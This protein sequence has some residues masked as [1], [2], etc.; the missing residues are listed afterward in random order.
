[1]RVNN[2]S[3]AL[4]SLVLEETYVLQISISPG[5]ATIILDALEVQPSADASSSPTASR[6]ISIEFTGVTSVAGR[7][8]GLQPATDA[9]GELD[10]GELEKLE[11][12]G[13]KYHILGEF[14]AIDIEAVEVSV[15]SLPDHHAV[16]VQ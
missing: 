8:S 6:R 15:D 14:G 7:W 10:Y 3:D 11:Q 2:L 9:S 16:P 4:G 12:T 1:M 13:N 5:R